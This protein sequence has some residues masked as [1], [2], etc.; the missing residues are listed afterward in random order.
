MTLF[1]DT[2]RFAIEA[3]HEPDPSLRF[4]GSE[5]LGRMRVW[6]NGN[7]FGDWTDPGCPFV[8]LLQD[9]QIVADAAYACWHQSLGS[10]TPGERFD[11]LDDLLFHPACADR[12]PSPL[13]RASFITNSVECFD[14]IKGFALT[15]TEG[16]VQILLSDQ[17][18]RF[19]DTMIAKDALA[20]IADAF[21]SWM[22]G[23]RPE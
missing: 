1:G 5:P 23:L 17:E 4:M 9:V 14:G 21:E 8:G 13:D 6:V 15:P 11:A 18:T 10:R 3:L 16:V 20:S 7:A 22:R 2:T 19:A 12:V